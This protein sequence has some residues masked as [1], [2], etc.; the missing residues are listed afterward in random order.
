MAGRPAAQRAESAP[1]PP[2]RV[3]SGGRPGAPPRPRPGPAPPRAAS[4]AH[5]LPQKPVQPAWSR[6]LSFGPGPSSCCRSTLWRARR[7]KGVAAP[8][9]AL[10]RAGEYFGARGGRS[11]TWKANRERLDWPP[12]SASVSPSERWAAGTSVPCK[13]PRSWRARVP[14][15]PRHSG[16]PL[17]G[18]VSRLPPGDARPLNP[19]PGLPGHR[20]GTARSEHRHVR[21][22]GFEPALL[23]SPTA[24]GKTGL[25]GRR[26]L[27][28]G[29]R[30]VEGGAPVPCAPQH[31]SRVAPS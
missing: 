29:T 5:R 30:W 19:K 10:S 21:E 20:G 15:S 12:A 7:P 27:A 22:S 4:C 8:R 3:G 14:S 2:G 9:E 28:L 1:R 26:L 11:G 16:L 31:G 18:P 25:R 24:S 6:L 17:P 23:P 13:F